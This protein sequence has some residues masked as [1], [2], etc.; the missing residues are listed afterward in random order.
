MKRMYFLCLIAVF[1]WQVGTAQDLGSSNR[2]TTTRVITENEQRQ[3]TAAN[4]VAEEAQSSIVYDADLTDDTDA[5]GGN[6]RT[7]SVI[8]VPSNRTKDGVQTFKTQNG[9]K[10]V[11][12]SQYNAFIPV[13]TRQEAL[14][15][16][17]DEFDADDNAAGIKVKKR[18]PNRKGR[19][20]VVA[21]KVSE[22]RKRVTTTPDEEEVIE[23]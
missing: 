17:L 3:I 10:V 5:T 4:A 7:R 18:S 22:N 13:R 9:R 1:G 12:S 11:Y 8:V 14:R 15:V 20:A 19:K 21:T 6:A 23:D 16:V 2:R